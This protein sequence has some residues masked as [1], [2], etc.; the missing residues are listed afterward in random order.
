MARAGLNYL[1]IDDP[2]RNRDFLVYVEAD[3]CVADA[4]S[5][6]TGCSLGKRR[7]KWMDYGKMAATFIDMNSHE[8]IRIAVAAKQN[9][10]ENGDIVAFW[11]AI[12]DEEL[13]KVEAVRVNLKP[14]DLPGKPLSRVKCE[15]CGESVMDSREILLGGRILC[16]ACA[17]GAYYEKL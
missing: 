1:G 4:V 6:V 13:F 15:R 16:R 7:L 2:L 8:G 14:E 9:A 10:P 12:P 5:S 17:N 11:N 3:R